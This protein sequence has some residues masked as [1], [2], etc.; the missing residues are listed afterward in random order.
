MSEAHTVPLDLFGK[1]SCKDLSGFVI[2][3]VGGM[4]RVLSSGIKLFT[5][6]FALA[7]LLYGGR[8]FH[9]NRLAARR[10]QWLN[11]RAHRF[12]YFRDFVRFYEVLATLA[13]YSAYPVSEPIAEPEAYPV[14]LASVQCF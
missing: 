10:A 12:S 1:P 8:L 9:K 7:G 4:P 6:F 11:W 2:S 13:A 14:E 3:W 5:V